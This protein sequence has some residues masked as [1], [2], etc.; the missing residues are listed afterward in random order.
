MN[1]FTSI[2]KDININKNHI[3]N[4]PLVSDVGTKKMQEKFHKNAVNQRNIYVTSQ[5]NKFHNYQKEIYLRIKNRTDKYMPSDRSKYFDSEKNKISK[6]VEA[7][8]FADNKLNSSY[9]LSFFSMIN[10]IN[11]NISLDEL[12]IILNNFI[13]GFKNIGVCLTIK[14]FSYTMFTKKYMGSF[15][16]NS[17]N[18]ELLRNC[19]TSIYW[20][21]PDFLK[22]LKLNLWFILEQYKKTLDTYCANINKNNLGDTTFDDYLN[23]YYKI[24]DE[25]NKKYDK[26]PYINL[27][28]F[29]VKNNI[30][31]YLEGSNVRKNTFDLLVDGNSF[32]S[33]NNEERKK[34]YLE[35]VDLSK[36][37]TVLKQ[38]HRYSFIVSDL[39]EKFKNRNKSKELYD[40]KLKEIEK[41]EHNRKKI[42]TSYDKACGI[43]LLCRINEQKQSV[44]KLRMNE[45]ILKLYNLYNELHELEI[46]YFFDRDISEISSLY[47]LFVCAYHSYFYLEKMFIS[48]FNSDNF[49]LDDEFKNYF[50]FIYNHNNVFLIKI[51]AFTTDDILEI[52]SDKYRMLGVN[53]SKD[54][55]SKDNIDLTID[56][57]NF[58]KLIKNIDDS[59]FS[60]EKINFIV[61]FK[62]I[63]DDT[64]L[65]IDS[66]ELL[67][68]L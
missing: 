56:N 22:H 43:G 26:D 41:E 13:V 14:D 42:F 19:F 2:D 30:D 58:I 16:D 64:L 12:N 24:I 21:C 51:N 57:V 55:I 36:T 9:K 47:D 37:L 48:N 59:E 11:D 54:D 45:E 62:K 29:L 63:E 4:Y 15:L 8:K 10:T 7:I 23:N 61:K 34:F 49:S 40:A 53:L 5:Q 27:N 6:M 28:N 35:I 32:E 38:Y 1:R 18:K 25:F 31:N 3:E 68:L 46:D 17:S 60:L 50:N 66:V 39:Q 67:N 20:E 65:S 52:I 44:Y 33:L